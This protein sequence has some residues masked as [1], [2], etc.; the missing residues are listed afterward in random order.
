M[1]DT[2]ILSSAE[3]KLALNIAASDTSQDTELA[4]YITAVTGMLDSLVGPVVARTVTSESHDGGTATVFLARRPVSSVTAVSEF[5]YTT[6]QALAAESNSTKT[7]NDYLLEAARGVLRRRS[8][9][10][11]ARF[12]SGRRNVLVTYS[13]GRYASTGAVEAKFKQAAAVAL[14][15]LWRREQGSGTETFGAF[16]PSAPVP[17][18]GLPNAVLDLLMDEVQAPEIG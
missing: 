15:N 4:S 16:E 1:A 3:A 18:F 6:E 17:G 13:A 12:A 8:G 7:A 11:D 14:T 5:S 2:D 9:G 10:G